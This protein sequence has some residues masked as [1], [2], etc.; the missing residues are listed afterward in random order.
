MLPAMQMGADWVSVLG[1]PPALNVP[2]GLVRDRE[3]GNPVSKVPDLLGDDYDIVV[4][5]Q[6]HGGNWVK[7]IDALRERGKIVLYEIDDYLHG[8]KSE[9]DHMSR[10]H[11][12]RTFLS[13]IEWAMRHCD[14]IICSTEYIA[15]MYRHFNK[16][17]FVCENGID[18]RRYDLTRPKRGTV[19]IGWAGATGHLAAVEPWVPAIGSIMRR[20][21]NTTF[22]SVGRTDFAEGFAKVFGK[23]RAIGT[24][25]AAIEQYP[26]A[27][28]MIDIALAPAR[29][30]NWWRGKSDLRWLEASALGIPVIADP[31]NY[32]Q[33][34]DG[35]TG[36]LAESPEQVYELLVMLVEDRKLRRK[37]G[38]QAREHVRRWR[39]MEAVVENWKQVFT[40]LL[41]ER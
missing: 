32:K 16:R 5:Q 24:P 8:I 1:E 39:S 18:T 28:T 29:P 14:G 2:S 22:V 17:V 35:V 25:W 15:S 6:P 41:G 7:L 36:F 27:M 12:D 20:N 9:K 31:Q 13:D 34:E 30:T 33:I 37:V 23:H 26:A 38:A 21:E 19:N 3:T 11:F 4:I 40:E 10:E